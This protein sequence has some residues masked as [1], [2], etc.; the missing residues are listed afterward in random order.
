MSAP[1]FKP[2]ETTPATTDW[3]KRVAKTIPGRGSGTGRKAKQEAWVEAA[4]DEQWMAA[5]RLL[6]GPHDEPVI[7]EIR[8]FPLERAKGRPPGRWS[9]EVLG[10]EATAPSEGIST[11]LLRRVHVGEPAKVGARF[12]KWLRDSKA[13]KKVSWRQIKQSPAFEALK[14]VTVTGYAPSAAATGKKRGRPPLHSDEFYAKLARDYA[15]WVAQGSRR[16]TTEIARR[17]KWPLA[18]ARDLI[19]QARQRGLLSEIGQGRVGGG[20]TAK[21]EQLLRK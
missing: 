11:E 13:Q 9:A 2:H 6:P 1:S 10:I 7:A 19:R 5:Y 14:G 17:R 18:K 21:A 20:L 8:I 15:A 16:P 12:A 4:V 3:G